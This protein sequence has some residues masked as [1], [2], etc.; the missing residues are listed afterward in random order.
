MTQ[1]EATW[2]ERVHRWRES[3]RSADQ[4]AQG[5]GFEASTLRYWASRLRT[6]AAS[7]AAGAESRGS[8]MGMPSVGVVRVRRAWTG[9]STPTSPVV[10]TSRGATVVIA[11]GAAR[12]EVLP[13]FDPALLAQVVI[14]LKQAEARG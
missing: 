11:I 13:G 6:K 4:F 1:T 2:A 14:A 3:G 12:I 7:A 8:A 9:T 10:P 5:Q